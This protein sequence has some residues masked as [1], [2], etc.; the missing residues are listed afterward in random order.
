[1]CHAVQV[2]VS[3][4]HHQ[5]VVIGTFAGSTSAR[6]ALQQLR[7][8]GPAATS[9][10]ISRQSPTAGAPPDMPAFTRIFWSGLWWSIIGAVLGG[11]LG[12]VVGL[13]G[14][15]VP[16]TPD[17]VGIQIA[18]WAMFA[19]VL[20][21]LLGCYLALDTGDR[22]AQK[23]EHHDVATTVLRVTTRDPEAVLRAERIM[24]DSGALTVESSPAAKD[25]SES[26]ADQ[27]G[28]V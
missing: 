11:A 16:G 20:G 22:F 19:H 15:G 28:A 2:K 26:S 17:N 14:L 10:S 21:A 12:L 7:E 23:A 3:D 18:A 9:V 25:D 27:A 5:L 13:L 1:M 6:F 8:S 24:R 4:S